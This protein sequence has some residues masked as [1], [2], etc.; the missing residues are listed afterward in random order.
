[1]PDHIFEFLNKKT[2]VSRETF[3]RL[4][5]YHDLLLK[6]QSK[7]NLIGPDTIPDSW[8]RH[9]LDSLQ[10]QNHIKNYNGKILDI[11]SGAGFPGMVLAVCGYQ[12]IHLV[13]S[14]SKK[15][16]FL[17]EVARITNTNVDIYNERVENLSV[18]N[19]SY[20]TS[21]AFSSL[22]KLFSL[23]SKFVSHETIC[24][25][26]KGKNYSMDIEEAKQNWLFDTTISPSITDNDGVIL[27]IRNIRPK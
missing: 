16:L 1:M 7:V 12:N 14:D 2:D 5:L 22:T 9:F 11:G 20:I 18:D 23:S 27:E 19:V 6:W 17:R 26:H 21:R 13:E 25:F 24:L 10:L 4:S 3:E 8:N 15:V